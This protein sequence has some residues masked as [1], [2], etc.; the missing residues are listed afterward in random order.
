MVQR[1]FAD[2]LVV[3]EHDEQ[4]V[5]LVTEAAQRLEER[6]DTLVH[7]Q[8][9][10][11]VVLGE[12][13]ALAARA[14][15]DAL[16]AGEHASCGDETTLRK[17]WVG[18]D[19]ATRPRRVRERC[20]Q[21]K[22]VGARVPAGH[23]IMRRLQELH[24]RAGLPVHV[25]HA[26]PQVVEVDDVANREGAGEVEADGAHL[27]REVRLARRLVARLQRL[28]HRLILGGDARREFAVLS[29]VPALEVAVGRR[30][31]V[32]ADETGVVPCPL[33]HRAQCLC[34]ARA[35]K[36]ARRTARRRHS[37]AA[38]RLPLVAPPLLEPRVPGDVD[39]RSAV[40][41]EGGR[42]EGRR[43]GQAAGQKR[44]TR[45]RAHRHGHV[46]A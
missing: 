39:L 32:L 12:R 7:P 23:V 22:E 17:A 14:L 43:R 6:A 31:M 29:S 21:V 11:R 30:Q 4:G 33:Q 15:H 25:V 18:T 37:G 34:A 40:A 26:K 5:L 46:R 42:V 13:A 27:G 36:H 10:R 16:A 1:A 38:A 9:V 44:I 35:A 24:A 28:G 45:W 8:R 3:R 19:A 41:L 20:A 2:A